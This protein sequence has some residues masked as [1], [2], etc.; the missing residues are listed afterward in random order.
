MR[1]EAIGVTQF[2]SGNLEADTWVTVVAD[3]A[4]GWDQ[5]Q[6]F[7]QMAEEAGMEVV[8]GI[9]ADAP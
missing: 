2:I 3:Y 6:W 8:T 1:Q 5:E 7:A 4:W 9:E